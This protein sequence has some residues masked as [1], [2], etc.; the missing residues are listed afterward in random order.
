[1]TEF[2]KYDSQTTFIGHNMRLTKDAD[3]KE[4]QKGKMVSLTVVSTSRNDK[5]S[6]MW[7]E[8]LVSDFHAELAAHLIKGDTIGVQGFMVLQK[9]GDPERVALKLRQAQVYT[10]VD[11]FVAA[12]ERGFTPGG[13]TSAPK[14]APAKAGAKPVAKKAAMKP[15]GRKTVDL[16][17]GDDE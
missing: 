13:S 16:D 8:V 10:S 9:Y 11:L 4:G 5:D 1:M 6:D 7:I 14:G 2:K 3:V 12:K 17:E 15:A